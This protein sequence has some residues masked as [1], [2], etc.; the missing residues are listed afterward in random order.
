MKR[1]KINVR[2]AETINTRTGNNMQEESKA[3][4]LVRKSAW[5]FLATKCS[6]SLRP[7][8]K[9]QELELCPIHLGNITA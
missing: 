8:I 6:V 9:G 1:N 3:V 2:K 4:D 5:G 7:I